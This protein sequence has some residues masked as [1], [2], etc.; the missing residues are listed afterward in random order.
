M[1]SEHFGLI[2]VGLRILG[3]QLSATRYL[4]GGPEAPSYTA[5]CQQP[6]RSAKY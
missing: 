5:I 1:E 3:A 2:N 6:Q 4:C